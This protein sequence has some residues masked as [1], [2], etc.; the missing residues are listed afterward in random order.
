[1]V[2]QSDASLGPHGLPQP[3]LLGKA[4]RPRVRHPP[5]AQKHL[6]ADD[7]R[8]AKPRGARKRRQAF[9]KLGEVPRLALGGSVEKLEKALRVGNPYPDRDERQ[10]LYK[11]ND[12]GYSPHGRSAPFGATG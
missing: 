9:G 3:R 10:Q 8:H 11:T 6:Q 4:E 2:G 1:T 7:Q 12:D 5:L